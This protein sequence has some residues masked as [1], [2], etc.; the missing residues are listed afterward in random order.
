MGYRIENKPVTITG[1]NGMTKIYSGKSG[2]VYRYRNTAIKIFRDG[3]EQHIDQETARYLTSIPTENI[4]LPRKLVFYNNAFRGFTLKLVPKKGVGKR[5]ISSPKEELLGNISALESDAEALSGRKVLLNDITPENS[6]YNG[7][8]YICNPNRYSLL[9]V[10]SSR[11][12]AGINKFQIHLLLI[13]LV[14]QEMKK[15]HYTQATI[16]R[17]REI[18]SLK[19][20]DQ[21]SSTFFEEVIDG[22][23]TIKQMIKKLI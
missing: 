22:K 12:L 13:E 20:P 5:I 4:L 2:D 15:A 6:M 19:D 14:S 11:D 3:D 18:L 16:N 8:L 7:E 17:F 23:S 21:D 10:D 1:K 9:D